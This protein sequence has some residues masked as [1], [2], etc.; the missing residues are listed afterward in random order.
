MKKAV[1]KQKIKAKRMEIKAMPKP[2]IEP[3]API[4]GRLSKSQAAIQVRPH[5]DGTHA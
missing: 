3:P 4:P 1:A 2:K 5:P